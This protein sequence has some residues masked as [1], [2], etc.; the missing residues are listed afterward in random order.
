MP[1]TVVLRAGSYL[2]PSRYR[3]GETRL[4]ATGGFDLRVLRWSVFGLFD[5]STLF[6]VS[7]AL[8]GARDYFGW[9][10]GAGIFR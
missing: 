2:E 10:I 7:L 4:H 5:E 8:D 1:V 3:T 9:S 6:R